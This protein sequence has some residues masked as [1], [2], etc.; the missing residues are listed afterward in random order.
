MH[1]VKIGD[2]SCR[3][4][5][6][7]SFGIKAAVRTSFSGGRGIFINISMNSPRSPSPYSIRR[8]CAPLR[9]S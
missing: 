9:I 2:I 1:A 3:F 8:T 4:K 5:V 6:V 7:K